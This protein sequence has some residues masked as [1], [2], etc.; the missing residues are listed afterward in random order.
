MEN[1]TWQI[2]VETNKHE[3]YEDGGSIKIPFRFYKDDHIDWSTEKYD[4]LLVK[5]VIIC[6]GEFTVMCE[7]QFL[8]E[9]V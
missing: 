9:K 5:E 7:P 3:Y 1:I 4:Y 6:E 8:R 2:L